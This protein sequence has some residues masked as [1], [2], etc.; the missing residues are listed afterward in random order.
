MSGKF[1]ATTRPTDASRIFHPGR[2][3]AVDIHITFWRPKVNARHAMKALLI[4]R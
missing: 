1:T 4:E 3:L 2:C